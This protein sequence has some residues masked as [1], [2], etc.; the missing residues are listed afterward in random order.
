MYQLSAVSKTASATQQ[1][2]S[3]S[4]M[5][6]HDQGFN[7]YELPF[8]HMT[9][10]VR[11]GHLNYHKYLI[12]DI[13][14]AMHITP[15]HYL[16][17]DRLKLKAADGEWNL[18]GHFNGSNPASIYFSPDIEVKHVDLDKLMMKF[19]NFGQDYLVS[20][21]LHGK[22]SGHI[23]GKLR[24]HKDLVPIINESEI[25]LDLTVTEGRL[26]NFSMLESMSA[27]F[28]DKNL[29]RVAFDTLSNHMDFNAGI[30]SIPTMTINSSIGFMDIKGSQDMDL[31][32]DYYVRIPWKMV[33]NAAASKLFGKKAEEVDP[34]QVDDIQYAKD[35]K[36]TRFVN[37]R[38]KGNTEDYKI[39]LEKAK[40]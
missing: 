12:H 3:A 17:I 16:H 40:S 28:A 4:S 14:A 36:K 32:M 2:Q 23:T 34:E 31:N 24:M 26:D 11:I 27:Y 35:G 20:E 8:S 13:D 1:S 22:L 25:H 10:D 5:A 9:F 29:K 18:K 37:V 15:D 7:I 21:N 30:L 33:T 19:D 6:V 38:I 39:T